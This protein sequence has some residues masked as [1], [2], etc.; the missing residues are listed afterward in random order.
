MTTN[1]TLGKGL[2]VDYASLSL[3]PEPVLTKTYQPVSHGDLADT[4]RRV[5]EDI[6]HDFSFHKEQYGLAKDGNQMFGIHTYK[7]HSDEMG[8]SIGFRNSY[9]KSLAIGLAMGASIFV[10]D[11]LAFTGDV[12]SF[13]KHTANVLV[14]IEKLILSTI[15]SHKSNY[16]E[17]QEE[18][19]TLKQ[20]TVT[21]DRAFSL[22]GQLYGKGILTPR[23]LPIVK[24]EWLSPTYEDFNPRT[25]W[26]FYN[27]VTK[28]LKTTPPRQI[29][30]KHIKLHRF[31]VA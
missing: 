21:N 1:L 6:L 10:C 19:E 14:D 3:I 30:E 23:Q 26:S 7:N 5:G 16:Y 17:I 9:D 24:D 20:R 11:N 2:K 22:M 28:G 4:V 8:L 12:T 25:M 18:A 27:A 31:L 29:M 15:Y 13:R